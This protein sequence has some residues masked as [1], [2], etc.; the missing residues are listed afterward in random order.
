[1][2]D[3]IHFWFISEDYINTRKL[4]QQLD[5]LSGMNV[6]CKLVPKGETQCRPRRPRP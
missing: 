6:N 4:I 5:K 3:E 2:G 1:M